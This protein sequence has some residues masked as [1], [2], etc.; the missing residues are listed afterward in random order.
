MREV[1]VLCTRSDEER[2]PSDLP[3]IREEVPTLVQRTVGKRC[4]GLGMKQYGLC[5][6]SYA[7]KKL[8]LIQ[9]VAALRHAL[10]LH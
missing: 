9:C 1:R 8:K 4:S 5:I 2:T 7:E 10:L 6:A 3:Y